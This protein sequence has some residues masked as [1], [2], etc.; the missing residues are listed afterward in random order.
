MTL[1]TETTLVINT[2]PIA[3]KDNVMRVNIPVLLSKNIHVSAP[4]LDRAFLLARNTLRKTLKSHNLSDKFP[5][6]DNSIDFLGQHDNVYSFTVALY[7]NF[8]QTMRGYEFMIDAIKNANAAFLG[9]S[10]H[11]AL[12][13]TPFNVHTIV[14]GDT[15]HLSKFK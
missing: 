13:A 10:E 3:I 9:S 8:Y 5:V 4:N 11:D 1:A 14:C 12:S 15:N 2:A 7:G 6:A